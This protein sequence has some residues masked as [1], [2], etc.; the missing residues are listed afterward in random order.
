ME[1]FGAREILFLSTIFL[2]LLQNAACVSKNVE[3]IISP[4]PKISENFSAKMNK[5]FILWEKNM[6]EIENCKK[7]E[8]FENP[9]LDKIAEIFDLK[10]DCDDLYNDEITEKLDKIF[11]ENPAELKKFCEKNSA[12]SQIGKFCQLILEEYFPKK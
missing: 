5:I 10:K 11:A 8:N 4:P 1:K 3:K 7:D 12:D 9:E 2:F 6:A